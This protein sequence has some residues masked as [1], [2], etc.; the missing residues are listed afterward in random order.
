V[1]VADQH[2]R[3]VPKSRFQ[4]KCMKIY[5]VTRSI[6]VG[7]P[8]YP[9]DPP[10]AIARVADVARGDPFTLSSVS[11]SSHAGTHVDAPC[12]V[13]PHGGAV[14]GLDLDA[15]I[16]RAL[17]VGIHD[18]P[19]VTAHAL[20]RADISPETRRLLLKTRRGQQGDAFLTPDAARW[21]VDRDIRLVGIDTL[22]VDPPGS[23]S[24]G[25]HRSLLEAGVV[26]IEGLELAAVPPGEH[27]LVCLPL[28]LEG[29]DG[30]P[31]R[32]VLLDRVS[33]MS[34]ET[35]WVEQARRLVAYHQEALDFVSRVG[36][37]LP[38]SAADAALVGRLW[39]EADG[40]DNLVCALL[41]EM[42]TGLLEGKGALDATR[43][44]SLGPSASSEE[45]VFYDCVWALLWGDGRG[46]SVNLA[47]NS[48][49][50]DY[51][52]SVRSI[53]AKEVQRIGFPVAEAELK[54]ALIDAYVAEVTDTKTSVTSAGVS[55]PS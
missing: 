48:G 22:S 12:H 6:S 9:G 15:M 20:E 52:V 2:S 31:A 11:I 10:T 23:L 38:V 24:L 19:E 1:L 49:S 30:A 21:I 44:A 46:V 14:D 55:P 37:Q 39:L 40:L 43:G 29:C 51:E 54:G 35:P 13:M 41:D 3:T 7:T 34:E 50:R 17:V 5:D 53:Q 33:L 27:T 4:S 16:G 18:G 28:K 36:Q 47:V 45:A 26:V 8:S 32:V 42:N 25:A